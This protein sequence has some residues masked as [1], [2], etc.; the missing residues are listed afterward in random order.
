MLY[1]DTPKSPSPTTI[2]A[3]ALTYLA[4][5]VC[6]VRCAVCAL[7]RTFGYQISIPRYLRSSA[8]RD[9]GMA[10]RL[11]RTRFS[12]SVSVLF[13]IPI[14]RLPSLWTL[15]FVYAV[16]FAL[17]LSCLMHSFVVVRRDCMARMV[18][19]SSKSKV[20]FLDAATFSTVLRPSSHTYEVTR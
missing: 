14:H 20:C 18:L 6:G 19:C 16:L 11:D 3:D 12:V 4:Q 5:M 2:N 8:L 13:Q 7:L 9:A 1:D 17:L 10:V 15:R